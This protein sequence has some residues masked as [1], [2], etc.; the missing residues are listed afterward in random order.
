[1]VGQFD[2]EAGMMGAGPTINMTGFIGES[3]AKQIPLIKKAYGVRLSYE[4]SDSEKRQAELALLYFN[5]SEKL[6]MQ[7]ND[8]LD[9]ML[10]PFKDNPDMQPED[11]MKARAAIRRFRDTSIDNF[12][13]F[14]QSAF[15]CVNSMQTFSTDTQTLKLMK[16]FINSI[17][18][19]EVKV[20]A[21]SDV[22]SDLQSKD[23]VKNIVSNIE[24]IQKQCDDIEEIIDERIKT[25][26]QTNIL[27][28]SWVDSISSDLQ[29]KIEQKTP[30]IMDLYNK[31]E[32][33]LNDAVENRGT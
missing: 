6:L 32:D 28:T 9:M 18:E 21:F 12:D 2:N 5:V 8:F 1:M 30:L 15:K 11:V 14:K 10:T 19:L 4:V 16:S 20:N 33:Q 31:R 25:H 23:F 3:M 17:D 7:A 13:K 22:F 29:M 27:A 26:I 24:N